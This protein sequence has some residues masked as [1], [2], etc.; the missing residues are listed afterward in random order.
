MID[1]SSSTIIEWSNMTSNADGSY[2]ND[3]IVTG[4]LKDSSSITLGTFSLTYVTGSNGKYQ[5]YITPAMIS[6]VSP[7]DELT[8]ELTATSGGATSFRTFTEV[9][10][11]RGK[12]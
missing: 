12:R 5:G 1:L 8:I 10:N 9:A 2:V 7:C 11:Y 3:A 4:A 6:A